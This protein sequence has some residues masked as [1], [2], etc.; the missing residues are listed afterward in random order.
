MF[1]KLACATAIVIAAVSN[2]S[3]QT[4]DWRGGGVFVD[5]T[6]CVGFFNDDRVFRALYRHPGLGGNTSDTNLSLYW[7]HIAVNLALL[8]AVFDGTFQVA[9]AT[10]IAGEARKFKPRIK[11][12]KMTPA[13][14]DITE[15]TGIIEIRGTIKKFAVFAEVAGCSVDFEMTLLR[16]NSFL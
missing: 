9:N 8:N 12:Q 6:N 1:T 15:E 13:P 16:A 10:S 5:Q 7:P 11:V 4:V 2:A 14:A 3:A